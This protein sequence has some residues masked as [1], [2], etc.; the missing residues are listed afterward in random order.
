VGK[1]IVRGEVVADIVYRR[2]L[3]SSTFHF[4]LQTER[5]EELGSPSA[6]RIGITVRTV[7]HLF[8]FEHTE[9]EMGGIVGYGV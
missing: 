9:E 4:G 5:A 3:F 2:F 6:F 7:F 1:S 8:I